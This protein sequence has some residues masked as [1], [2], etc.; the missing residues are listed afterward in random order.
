MVFADMASGLREVGQG[1]VTL[2]QF[3]KET[4]VANFGALGALFA[5]FPLLVFAEVIDVFLNQEQLTCRVV[6]EIRRLRQELQA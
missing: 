3:L 1:D 4:L 6:N 5:L 2:G